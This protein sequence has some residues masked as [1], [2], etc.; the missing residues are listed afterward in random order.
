MCVW[1]S[2]L[3]LI[4]VYN[5]L[6]FMTANP[7]PTEVTLMGPAKTAE[8]RGGFQKINHRLGWNKK[9]SDKKELD[10]VIKRITLPIVTS[11][12]MCQ[13]YLPNLIQSPTIKND[14]NGA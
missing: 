8:S 11:A 12:L 6:V 7:S 14:P 2:I 10:H 4:V 13:S 3:T 5:L 1:P 9:F